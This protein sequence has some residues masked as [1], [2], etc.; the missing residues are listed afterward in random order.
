MSA[1]PRVGA[2]LGPGGTNRPPRALRMWSISW[3][4]SCSRGQITCHRNCRQRRVLVG[5]EVVPLTELARPRIDVTIRI[6]GLFR[7]AFPNL[8]RLLNEAVA[9]VARLEEPMD[10]N[11]VRAH[12]AR[13]TA[14]LSTEY[15]VPSTESRGKSV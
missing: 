5:L 15:R 6:S 9:L 13:D 7:D 1:L 4:Q 11:H 12:V 10:W 2:P 14:L 3:W 8:V